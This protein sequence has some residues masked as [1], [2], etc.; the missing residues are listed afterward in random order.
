M[1]FLY[2]WLL[3][4]LGAVKLLIDRRAGRLERKYART[5]RAAD[6]LLREPLFK[7][8]NTRNPDPAQAAKRQYLVGQLVQ[9]RDRLEARWH[10]WQAGAERLR[11]A[12]AWVRG[13]K[14]RLV[15]YALGAVD[16]VAVLALA[17]YLGA[18][19]SVNVHR[20][21]QQVAVLF[22]GG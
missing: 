2:A 22:Q 1:I 11:R 18:G 9:K 4:F 5:A 12:V 8:G 3:L 6:D 20:L 10:A 15:P 13:W 21:V 7:G 14:G 19:E 16:V 17:D